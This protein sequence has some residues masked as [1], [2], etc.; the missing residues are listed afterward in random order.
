IAQGGTTI[1]NPASFTWAANSLDAYT[2]GTDDQIWHQYWDG[3]TFIP[4]ATTWQQDLPE[5]TTTNGV[6]VS[7]WGIGRQDMFV[8]TGSAIAHNWY[9]YGWNP[10]WNDTL[11]P[12]VA[13]VSAPSAVSWG[14]DRIDVVILGSDG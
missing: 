14:L 10:T 6:A 12:P 7:T 9:N 13:P 11:T 3:S 4:S 5:I 8:N 2:V 1:A